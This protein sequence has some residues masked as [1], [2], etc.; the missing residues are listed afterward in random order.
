MNRALIQNSSFGFN[1]F[2]QLHNKLATNNIIP[3]TKREGSISK[4]QF[5]ANI[6]CRHAERH[7]GECRYAEYHYGECRYAECRGAPFSADIDLFT[8]RQHN[9]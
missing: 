3:Y 6:E 8:I 2:I 7:Y 9:Q 4:G 1:Y 5:V